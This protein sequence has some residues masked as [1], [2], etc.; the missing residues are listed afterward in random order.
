MSWTQHVKHPSQMVSM[1]QMVE[2]I[3]LNIDKDDKKTR[4][5]YEA[6]RTRPMG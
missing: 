4:S 2:A 1:G 5:R 6:V 3:V